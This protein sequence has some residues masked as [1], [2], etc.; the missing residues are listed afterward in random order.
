MEWKICDIKTGDVFE[1]RYEHSSFRLKRTKR[2]NS[3]DK[4]FY[5]VGGTGARSGKLNDVVEISPLNDRETGT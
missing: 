5:V 1:E 4:T 3:K 2:N